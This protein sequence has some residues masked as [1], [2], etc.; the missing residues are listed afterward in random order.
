[1]EPTTTT[2]TTTTGVISP[3]TST[4]QTEEG[5]GK[6]KNK[7]WNTRNLG[8]RIAADGAAA[9]TAGVL[10]APLITMIDRYVSA[11]SLVLNESL[12]FCFLS[13]G[14]GEREGSGIIEEHLA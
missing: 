4:V 12:L 2:K 14:L 13:C 6:T 3:A 10:V 5:T 1:M 7:S 9:A 11:F 8:L